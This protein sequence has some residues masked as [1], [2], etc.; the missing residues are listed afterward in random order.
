[1]LSLEAV[2]YFAIYLED[3]CIVFEFWRGKR[4]VILAQGD[5][6]NHVKFVI[7]E[8]QVF[9]GICFIGVVV[10]VAVLMSLWA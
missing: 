2:A 6:D 5:D 8:K 4:E 3:S 10:Q 7:G 9:S 1:M